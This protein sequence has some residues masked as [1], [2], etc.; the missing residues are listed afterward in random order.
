MLPDMGR[1]CW[2]TWGSIDP[3]SVKKRLSELE[4]ELIALRRD[5]HAHPELGFQEVRT[6]ANVLSG[7]KAVQIPARAAADTGV[8]GILQ[9]P[10]PGRTV[11][12]RADMD[13]LPIHEENDLAHRSTDEIALII[14][15]EL[16]MRTALQFLEVSCRIFFSLLGLAPANYIFHSLLNCLQLVDTKKLVP[17]NMMNFFRALKR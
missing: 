10:R 16:Y 9:D 15:A 12:L 2:N 7:L 5:L 11:L 6:Q 8:L 1:G 4:P 13:A 14:G 3:I 17:I